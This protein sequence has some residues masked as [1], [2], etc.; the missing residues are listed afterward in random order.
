MSD[1]IRLSP[2]FLHI[3]HEG[4]TRGRWYLRAPA[5]HTLEDVLRPEYFGQC[6]TGAKPLRIPDVIEVEAEDLSWCCNL[7]VL[8]VNAMTRR[9]ITR[10]KGD[11]QQFEAV[12]SDEQKAA[13]YSLKFISREGGWAVIDSKGAVL[14]QGHK[15]AA[16]ALE[17]LNE[18]APPKAK[19]AA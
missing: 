6:T 8:S 5:A 10:L 2:K 3:E 1:P 9:V 17:K 7:T 19:K 4:A 11:V 12:L 14:D 13:G 18:I 16:A 15:T